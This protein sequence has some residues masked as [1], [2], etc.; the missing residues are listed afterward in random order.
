MRKFL[1]LTV[2]ALLLVAA[3]GCLF[4]KPVPKAIKTEITFTNTAV[5][6]G[7]KEVEA[8][9]DDAA[10]A[11]KALKVLKR[12]A[13]HTENLERFAKGQDAEE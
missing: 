6:V 11:A 7:I 8:L 5:K 1:P 10:K 13:P 12:I 3:P 4:C 2:M 9:E